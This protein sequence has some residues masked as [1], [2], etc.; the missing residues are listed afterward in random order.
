MSSTSHL[1]ATQTKE[2]K[3]NK[4]HSSFNLRTTPCDISSDLFH[5]LSPTTNSNYLHDVNTDSVRKQS[6]SIT[7]TII[8]T[9]SIPG[10]SLNVRRKLS[11][12]SL[13]VPWYKRARSS[14]DDKSLTDSIFK[15]LHPQQ[16]SHH[17][18]K[19]S[20]DRLLTLD[21]LFSTGTHTTAMTSDDEQTSPATEFTALDESTRSNEKAMKTIKENGY[22]HN[23]HLLAR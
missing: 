14:S 3:V 18:H 15:H 17:P 7:Q 1:T 12:I 5:S 2:T 4:R 22:L 20:R 16:K 10:P 8:P 21:R 9:P 23:S 19:M 6:F 13:P 11:A